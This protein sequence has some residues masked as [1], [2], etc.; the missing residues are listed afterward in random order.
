MPPINQVL[1]TTYSGRTINVLQPDPDDILIEDIAHALGMQCRYNGHTRKFYS[2]AE[3][4]LHVAKTTG[5]DGLMHDAAEA[6]LGDIHGMLKRVLP[7]YLEV[8]ARFERVLYAKFGL[9][10]PMPANVHTADKNMLIYEM[11]ALFP[12]ASVWTHFPEAHVRALL[13]DEN[14]PI[15][16]GWG[17]NVAEQLFLVAFYELFF[18]GV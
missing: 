4:C 8:E 12:P 1:L 18:P 5:L 3:H 17:P 16:T 11:A 7:D 9:V 2:V 15:I 13:A 14:A 10:Y 6:Y